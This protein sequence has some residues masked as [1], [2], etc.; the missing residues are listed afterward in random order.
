MRRRLALALLLVA[1]PVRADGPADPRLVVLDAMASELDRSMARLKLKGFEPP[2]FVAYTVRDYDTVDLNAKNG[3]LFGDSRNHNRQAYVEVRV[4]DYQFDNTAD[5]TPTNDMSPVGEEV[6]EPGAEIAIDDDPDALR[7]TL[8]LLT[9]SRYKAALSTLNQRRGVR[10]TTV[11]EDENLPSFA[12]AEGAPHVVDPPRP[13]VVDRAAWAQRLRVASALMKAH[14]DVFESDVRFQVTREVRHLV[15]SEGARLVT[16]RTIYALHLQ[17]VTRADDGLLL[18]HAR[19]FYGR[20]ETDLPDAAAIAAAVERLGADLD[21]LRRAPVLSP[22]TGPAILMEEATG[23]LFHEVIGHRLEGERI[24]DDHEGQ[25]FKGQLGQAVIPRFLDVIDDPTQHTVGSVALN[26]AYA[27]DD[28]AIAA[29]PVTLIEQGV[30]RTYLTS[31]KPVPGA[32]RSNGHGRAEGTSDP[33]AR[34]G[35]TI[36]RSTHQVP[37]A[38]LKQMLLDEVRRQGKPFGL[39]IRDI[40]GGSTN[41]ASYGYQ[42][43]KGTPRLVYKVD[44]KTGAETLVRGVEMVGTPLTSINKIVATGDHVGVFNGFC[45]AESGFV[46]VSTVAPAVLLTEIELQRA[47]RTRQKQTI[48]P[49]PW[50]DRAAP[51]VTR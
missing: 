49:P 36:V 48:L 18:E 13:L 9:D 7:G 17:G 41:T 43:F 42:A 28:E 50:A 45:G 37:F 40:T 21:A 3:A 24:E 27:F 19:S 4:G 38:K 12:R 25:T 31:R 8:W 47:Q 30:L 44:A 22:Y 23:V 20:A 32:A 2:Y 26:G 34:M 11:V 35:N 39:I 29:R 6:Y 1:V 14:P 5:V 51:A 15:T 10:A 46:P 33:M 16:E